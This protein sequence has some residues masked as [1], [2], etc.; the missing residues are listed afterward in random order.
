MRNNENSKA[1]ERLTALFD[2]GTFTR[3]DAFAKSSSGDVE[4][5][6]GFGSVD[7]CSAY[8]FSQDISV[9]DGAVSV[10]QC[11]TIEKVYELAVKTGCPVIGI[12]DS[13]GVKLTL[14]S[15]I[16]DAESLSREVVTLF[17]LRTDLKA[18]STR[19]FTSSS[20]SM[21]TV[22]A[23]RIWR[24][25]SAIACAFP[26]SGLIELRILL[27]TTLRISRYKSVSSARTTA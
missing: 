1:L 24:S 18:A 9:S 14:T 8:A 5:V 13:N 19:P 16:Y 15:R 27:L 4:V 20:T 2:D 7:G 23:A 21:K 11:A 3:I 22:T 6:A 26:Y 12:Y 10:A 17:F 25:S